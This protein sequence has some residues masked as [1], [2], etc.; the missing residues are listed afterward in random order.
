MALQVIASDIQTGNDLLLV[1]AAPKG[2]DAIV[3][4]DQATEFY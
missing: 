3:T 2:V 1:E 4:F